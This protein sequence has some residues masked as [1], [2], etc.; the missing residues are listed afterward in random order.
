M[1]TDRAVEFGTPSIVQVPGAGDAGIR[2]WDLT[3]D[4]TGIIRVV[5][6]NGGLAL[7]PPIHV[8]VNWFTELESRGA[9]TQP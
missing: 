1:T 2:S 5:E 7:Q 3:P 6:T 4:G 9:S 8:V